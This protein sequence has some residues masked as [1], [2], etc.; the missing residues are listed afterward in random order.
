LK[1]SGQKFRFSADRADE[2][3]YGSGLVPSGATVMGLLSSVAVATKI[4]KAAKR[5]HL[6]VRNTDK[7]AVLLAGMK[8]VKPVLV[9]IDWD[10]CEREA[11]QLLQTLRQ[12]ES[13]KRLPV[14]GYVSN[15]KADLKGMAERAGCDRVYFKTDFLNHLEDVIARCAL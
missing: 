12:D 5:C 11:F 2:L 9:L 14:M 1:L 4:A 8:A 7:A 15:N 13:L 10:E 6:G 3:L